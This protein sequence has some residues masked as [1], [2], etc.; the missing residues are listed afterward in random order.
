M[1]GASNMSREAEGARR[2]GPFFRAIDP[3]RRRWVL[4]DWLEA[5]SWVVDGVGGQ[6]RLVLLLF[7][8][9]WFRSQTPLDDTRIR[10]V[11][12]IDVPTAL[13]YWDEYW[14]GEPYPPELVEAYEAWKASVEASQG[15]RSTERSEAARGS[16]SAGG[17][18]DEGSS[19][20]PRGVSRTS[21][22]GDTARPPLGAR[23]RARAAAS[24]REAKAANYLRRDPDATS[25]EV[26]QE[27]GI[28]EGTVRKLESWK[29]RENKRK[30]SAGTADAM[31]RTRPL[32]EKMQAAIAGKADDPAQLA[33][34]NEFDEVANRLRDDPEYRGIIESQYLQSVDPPERAAYHEAGPDKQIQ[35]LAAWQ[36]TDMT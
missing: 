31:R 19:A 4:I 33:Q 22:A 23:S 35:L 21:A 18:E 34:V 3:A 24:D 16:S 36:V 29:N 2:I 27:T 30:K 25:H 28:P 14:Q 12:E 15:D 5:K 17:S 32:T 7:R 11:D 6:Y 20:A 10:F 26:E 9:H 13:L 1:I 8:K